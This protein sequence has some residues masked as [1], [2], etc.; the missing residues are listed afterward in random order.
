MI[1][2]LAFLIMT[3]NSKL[4]VRKNTFSDHFFS[5]EALSVEQLVRKFGKTEEEVIGRRV[6]R[7]IVTCTPASAKVVGSILTNVGFVFFL[8]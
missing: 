4:W 7:K 6:T 1:E 5:E 8:S 3:T 2:K